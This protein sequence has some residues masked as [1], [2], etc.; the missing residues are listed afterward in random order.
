MKIGRFQLEQLSE[1]HFE[2]FHDGTI[3]RK[4]A[5]PAAPDSE[6]AGSNRPILTG[7]NPL[8]ITD[9]THHI[10]V[11]TGLG[12]GL[13]SGSPNPD[14]SN[15]VTNLNIFGVQPGAITHVILTHLHY[16]HAAGSTLTQAGGKTSPTFSNADYFVHAKEWQAALQ[17][18]VQ[19]ETPTQ[20]G[21]GYILDD[22]YRLMANEQITLIN[23]S[24]KELLPG[25]TLYW[26]G[27][28]T[29]GHQ[30]VHLHDRDQSAYFLGDLVP[31]EQHLNQYA[32]RI[33]DTEP[34]QAKKAKTRFLKK[35]LKEEAVLLFYHS[36][37]STAGKLQKDKSK[38]YVLK[39]L[40]S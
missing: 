38:R 30:V 34:L 17:A 36:L 29:E 9:G 10:L 39:Q 24:E 35:A 21:V 1:G 16:D 12:W 8:Y 40:S 27:G 19:Q 4:S 13:D 23:D 2:V 37:H 25:L 20:S 3:N 28:H 33:M 15:V 14:I 31:S 5:D 11:D 18:T 26:T 22:F 6:L 7:I 32:M